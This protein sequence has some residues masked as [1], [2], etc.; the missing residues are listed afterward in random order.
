MGS[1]VDNINGVARFVTDIPSKVAGAVGDAAAG[2]NNTVSPVLAAIRTGSLPQ[3]P[4]TPTVTPPVAAIQPAAAVQ[5]QPIASLNKP[6]DTPAVQAQALMPHTTWGGSMSFSQPVGGLIRQA[7]IPAPVN[8]TPGYST[9]IDKG[10]SQHDSQLSKAQ[11]AANALFGG[12][13]DIFTNASK[14]RYI[15]GLMG[16]SNYAKVQE[17][18]AANAFTE[19]TN[20][21]NVD[22]NNAHADA[23]NQETVKGAIESHKAAA[24]KT[25]EELAHIRSQTRQ[26]DAT[27]NNLEANSYG[28]QQVNAL[29]ERIAALGKDPKASTEEI[30]NLMKARS[31]LQGESLKTVAGQSELA[32]RR[33]GF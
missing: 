19:Q 31:A 15:A 16:D 32:D 7:D 18:G 10:I 14:A 9:A 5:P 23:R 22:T 17:S 4:A 6:M 27:A 25:P 11:D 33:N 13:S 1:T 24:M 2:I 20:Q 28:A 30:S 12:A 21:R 29:T 8:P 3:Q 26:A